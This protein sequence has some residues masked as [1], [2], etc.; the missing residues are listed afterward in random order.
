MS[1]DWVDQLIGEG[2]GDDWVSQLVSEEKTP[3]IAPVTKPDVSGLAHEIKQED[4]RERDPL[5]KFKGTVMGEAMKGIMYPSTKETTGLELAPVI[6]KEKS[7]TEMTEVLK[8][9]GR[10]ATQPIEIVRGGAEFVMNLP[11]FGLGV[12]TAGQKMLERMGRPFTLDDLYDAASSGMSNMTQWW[13]ESMVEPLIGKT[14]PETQLVGQTVMAPALFIAKSVSN[15]SNAFKDFPNIQGAMKF[16]GDIG[17]LAAL[18]AMIKGSK[19]EATA[20]LEAVTRKAED[21]ARREAAVEQIPSEA[22][23]K[24]QQQIIAAEKVQLE[25][26]AAAVQKSLDYGK[27]IREDLQGK[28]RR[29]AAAKITQKQ[30]LD[31]QINRA[32]KRIKE[33][34]EKK[35]EFKELPAKEE[36]PIITKEDVELSETGLVVPKEKKIKPIIEKKAEVKKAIEPK[37]KPEPEIKTELAPEETE[38]MQAGLQKI[39]DF[40]KKPVDQLTESEIKRFLVELDED[41]RID[42]FGEG[43]ERTTDLDFAT[44]TREPLDLG[45]AFRETAERTAFMDK[46]YKENKWNDNIEMIV[47]KYL[48]DVNSWLDGKE[49]DVEA[50]RNALSEAAVQ[51]ANPAN[52]GM[53]L[54]VF[55]QDAG[56]LRNFQEMV[57]EAAKWA[58]RADRSKI[59]PSMDLNMMIPLDQIPKA[60]WATLK[61]I[62]GVL[63][64]Y[65]VPTMGTLYRNKEIYDKTGYWLAHDG[66]W[67]KELN[68]EEMKLKI[69]D[70]MKKMYE[71]SGITISV[72]LETIL[73]YP[74]LYEEVPSTRRIIVT[75]D[76]HMERGVAGEYLD[77]IIRVKNIDDISN[78]S[79]EIQHAVNDKVGSSFATA[80]PTKGLKYWTH[81]DEIESRLTQ[82]RMNMSAAERKATPPWETLDT[83]LGWEKWTT[84]M[85]IS[86]KHG[87]KL[88][89]GIPL[90]TFVSEFSKLWGEA[91]DK[92][93]SSLYR[94]A[95]GYLNRGDFVGLYK[96]RD[97]LRA[98]GATNEASRL[99]EAIKE[100]GKVNEQ[101]MKEKIQAT[102]EKIHQGGTTLH[103]GIPLDEMA[104]ELV[105]GARKLSDYTKQARGMKHFKPT[106]AA[107]LLREEFNKAFV[108]RSGNIRRELLDQLGDEG[109]SVV[110]KMYLSKGASSLS[111]NM[112]Q[113]MRKEVY[114][115][116]NKN[117][118]R[119]LDN[120]ILA[121]RM[122]DIGG[123]KTKAQFR[124]PEALE[125]KNS[126]A[127]KELFEQIEKLSPDRAAEIRRRAEGYFEWMKKP[128]KDM[129]DAGLIS[130][131]E[132]NL[133]ASHNYRRIK[134]VDIFDKRYQAT[135]G[136]HSRTVYDS[137]IE[138][139]SR[140]H[141][142]D[143]F[144][145]S[146]EI[147]AL[148]VFN[149][150]YGRI[151]NNQANQSLLEVARKNPENP[152]VRV[153]EKEGG[154]GKIPSGWNRIFVYEEGVRK[155]IYL[156]PKMSAEWITSNPEMSYRLGQMLR[157]SSGSPVLRTFATGINWGFALANLPRDIMHSWFAA[158][159]FKDGQ[160]NPVF[161]PHAPIFGL[162]MGRN[163]ATV[164]RDAALKKGRYQQYIEEGGGMEFLVHQG[165]LFQRGRH[166][167]GN[168]DK[169]YNILGYFGE[170]SEILTRL[171]IRD[172]VIRNRA[173]EK[174]ISI[175]DARKDKE[176]TREATFAAR[177][178]M[179]FGQGGGVAKAA[180]NA[181]PYLNAA[182]QGTR[183]L[184]RSF[185]DN[186]VESTY[187]LAQFGSVVVG[188]YIAAT[189]MSPQTMKSLQGNIDMQ[190]NLCI[191][192]GDSFGFEDEKGQMRYPY[193]KIP[194]DPGQKFFKK[195]LEA[196]TDKWLGNE[197]DV[198]AVVDSLK[199][200]S[201]V[202]VTELP[203]TLSG[204]LG[205]VTNKDF[206][207][208]EDIWRKTDKPFSYPLSKEEFIP[209]QTPQA[210]VDLGQLTGLSPERMKY[211]VEELT[212]NGTFWSYLLG[213]GYDKIFG[214]LPKD[215]K[216]Q[217]LVMVLSQFPG[218]KRFIGVT[219]PYSQYAK[220]VEEAK[221]QSDVDRWI[222]TRGLD[223]R[224]EGYLFDK[225]VSKAEIDEY[226][227]SF[228]DK[229]VYDR[230]K[231][232]FE[233]QEKVKDLPNRS[234]WLRMKG[235]TAEARARVYMDRLNKAT[236]EEAAQVRS[237]MQTV[238]RAGGIITPEFREE[239]M[240]L[241]K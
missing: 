1:S 140:G 65:G 73:D 225:T 240:K 114:G 19:A 172:Q 2:G 124:F 226:M 170:T 138:A 148:E 100:L 88:Y 197:V 196:S 130:Q 48:N 214:N 187:K 27:M 137:G 44:G 217:H 188:T 165:R 35:I 194:L 46:W 99:G 78:L 18:G 49:L 43:G 220:G 31:F 118:K 171:A 184:V 127:Y 233:F 15:F 183:G 119:I 179:D 146:S 105:A 51:V 160:W 89:S 115:S 201:P 203:P 147:M 195:F 17:S 241:M 215:K 20:K 23:K 5:A 191:P 98:A 200:L 152:F 190:N 173:S 76:K 7:V 72:P 55:N 111:A 154:E 53:M 117:E 169:I 8:G 11:G 175:K 14:T 213:E 161:S 222:Q 223:V 10:L 37:V 158:R 110:Q 185:K 41:T 236:P 47:G 224:A 39:A 60:V 40:Y 234:L 75:F 212:T 112:L 142:T 176:I 144:E 178:Y 109:Y 141:D 151:L 80:G 181:F 106:V 85:R 122:I 79:H 218:I 199:E 9:Y 45:N 38:A 6:D 135:V 189:K 22:I 4:L 96:T 209:G 210:F 131:E 167:E 26:E 42:W 30:D 24:A 12:A 232:R 64:K 163:L 192:L 70:D 71:K 227:R 132:Y 52:R 143:I 62:R 139:L 164:F 3:E 29:V 126:I 86:K 166:L 230:L 74:K 101:R 66:R 206:W 84:D 113:Q 102:A 133:L 193:L 81:P 134:L 229:D 235:L 21:I 153:S 83:M 207:L 205:Y 32:M 156:S 28:G 67:R 97:D 69:P 58:R 107:Q 94:D 95:V 93:L 129:L 91:K 186:P 121:D 16:V 123:Y 92:K 155:P 128:L 145:P 116:L 202:G 221:E 120:L 237:E 168:I 150:A 162:Q 36:L 90:D 103:G 87:M 82:A 159:Q 239:V 216:E 208:N 108:D 50:S 198:N 219:N 177:D 68:P 61:E 228:K 204:A 104:R 211:A 57:S 63:N 182:I 157:Y 25:L 125:P 13:S 54:D 59:E 174:G 180:D 34:K 77:G 149:R 238:I 33:A 136:K 56:A 231:E